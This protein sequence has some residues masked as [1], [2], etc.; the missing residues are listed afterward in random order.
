MTRDY[1]NGAGRPNVFDALAKN[2]DDFGLV[3][4][5]R[6]RFRT[7][8]MAKVDAVIATRRAQGRDAAHRRGDLL[9]LLL[10]VRDPET[11][12]SLSDGEIRDQCMTMLAAGFETTSRLLFWATYLLGL[13]PEE[14][15]KLRAEV[16]AVPPDRIEV[17]D[18]LEQ[19]PRLRLVLLE[20]M[21][22]YPPAPYIVRK[23]LADDVIGGH[24]ITAGS[25]VWISPFVLHRHRKFW[26]NPTAF[27]PDRFAGQASPWTRL[28]GYMPFGGGPRICIGAAFALVEAQIILGTLLSRFGFDLD[29]ARPALPVF[30]ITTVPDHDP[31]F[32][33]APT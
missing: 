23:A 33:L 16:T 30:R 32:K 9:D 13:D 2:E 27:L 21:R 29:D 3:L 15:E 25:E 18:D 4:G 28:P 5:S 20:A 26:G 24:R 31:W 1:L 14:Q 6:R 17:I 12:D 11:G 22:L 19:W 7:A 10:A 8:W